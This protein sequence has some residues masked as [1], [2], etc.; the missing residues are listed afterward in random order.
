V[1]WFG[2]QSDQASLAPNLTVASQIYDWTGMLNEIIANR[3][4]GKLGGEAYILTLANGGLKI[5]F[6][7]A[8]ALPADVKA[9]ADAAIAESRTAP[10]RL[11]LIRRPCL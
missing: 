3:K 11:S 4:A 2:T 7:P 10:S 5:A 6:N 1:L 8:S 9:K